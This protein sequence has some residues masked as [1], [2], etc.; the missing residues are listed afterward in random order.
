MK[1]LEK[2]DNY[3]L[4]K[5]LE[6]RPVQIKKEGVVNLQTGEIKGKSNNFYDLFQGVKGF[7]AA[8]WKRSDNNKNLLTVFGPGSHEKKMSIGDEMPFA[9]PGERDPRRP[10]FYGELLE[11]TSL[12]K[13]K[14]S[15]YK[16]LEWWQ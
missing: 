1:I 10:W 4:E 12:I 9:K 13:L 8:I 3:L 5:K 7:Q 2:I 14:K 16:K 11:K 6:I 15:I